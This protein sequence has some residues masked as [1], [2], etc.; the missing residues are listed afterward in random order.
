MSLGKQE[1][2]IIQAEIDRLGA[3]YERA[4]EK[5]GATGS[6]S[7]D[8]TMYK[9]DTLKTALENYLYRREED[10]HEKAMFRYLDQLERA[11]KK[12]EDSYRAGKIEAQAYAEIVR[13]LM[14]G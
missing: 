10:A 6:A 14:E 13:I 2:K 12:V 3:A 1:T 9:Y 11:H 4:Q 5:Y 8:R 7:T